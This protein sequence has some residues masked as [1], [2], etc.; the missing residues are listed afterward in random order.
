LRSQLNIGLVNSQWDH[1]LLNKN[2]IL[3]GVRYG[4]DLTF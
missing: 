1:Y 2:L 3:A 4:F